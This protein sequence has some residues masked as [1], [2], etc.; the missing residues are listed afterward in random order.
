CASCRRARIL[1]RRKAGP[2]RAPPAP[3]SRTCQRD[4]SASPMRAASPRPAFLATFW[5]R[6]WSSV[7]SARWSPTGRCAPPRACSPAACRCGAPSCR[8]Q[9]WCAGLAA[10]SSVV[11]HT[12]GGWQEPI[13]CGGVA[14]FPGDI[15]VADGD[16]AVVI[17]QALVEEVA[18][19]GP[20]QERFENWALAEVQKGAAL[21]GLYPPNEATR[22]RYQA[23]RK[24]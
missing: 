16:G 19:L 3:P 18:K 24:K 9:V 4:A 1:P 8:W 21:P 14:V 5:W 11:G 7:A 23:E 13:G 12:F 15:I 6:A 20:E 2:R 10:P 22:A 17:P